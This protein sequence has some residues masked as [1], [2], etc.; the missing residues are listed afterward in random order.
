MGFKPVQAMVW[1]KYKFPERVG[2]TYFPSYKQIKI[3]FP[4]LKQ[5]FKEA[6]ED[7]KII[8]NII[9]LL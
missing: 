8:S 2:E 7:I 4:E 3:K 9:L 5:E 1:I 6:S